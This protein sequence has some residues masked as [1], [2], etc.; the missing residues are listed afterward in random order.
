[1]SFKRVSFGYRAPDQILNHANWLLPAGKISA[2]VG[3]S[4]AGKSTVI[5]LI[6]G[7][8]KPSQGKVKIDGVNLKSINITAWRH[9][10]GYVPQEVVLFND[11]IYNN[12]TLGEPEFTEA[13]VTE[14]LTAAGAISFVNELPNGM[15]HSVGER[16]NRLSGGQ[17]QRIAIA[18]ALV[19]RPALLILDEATTGLDRS[20][21]QE[22]CSAI[23]D[24]VRSRQI[25]VLAISHQPTWSSLADHVFFL[26]DR[27][28]VLQQRTGDAESGELPERVGETAAR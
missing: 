27:S 6:M 22:I 21:E 25:T 1:V 16:G 2:L 4:G 15:D 23:Q 14:A 20:T 9:K 18:R 19:H 5:D 7:L 24:L 3:A 13:D 11:T 17:R 10:I 28:I 8:R 12:V 26:R